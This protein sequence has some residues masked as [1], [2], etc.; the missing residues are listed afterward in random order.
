MYLYL[1]YKLQLGLSLFD[2]NMGWN[3]Q[4]FFLHVEQIANTSP[5]IHLLKLI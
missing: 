3:N 4:Y 2:P 1:L 5:T